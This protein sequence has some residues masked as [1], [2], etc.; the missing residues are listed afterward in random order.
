MLT[1]TPL[2][3][4]LPTLKALSQEVYLRYGAYLPTVRYCGT[5]G[6]YGTYLERETYY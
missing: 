2:P 1:G 5:Y 6:T 3:G 4:G